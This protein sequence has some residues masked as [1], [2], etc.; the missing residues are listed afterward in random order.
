MS[1]QRNLRTTFGVLCFLWMGTPG[2]HSRLCWVDEERMQIMA[3]S[4]GIEVVRLGEWVSATW[5][6]NY[7][8]RATPRRFV[9][10]NNLTAW[11]QDWLGGLR[12]G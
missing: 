5:R 11:S 9:N 1:K 3:Q 4:S 7:K 12:P 10:T 8:K 6:R 2:Q